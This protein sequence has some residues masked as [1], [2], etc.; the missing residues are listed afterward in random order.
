MPAQN[1]TCLL[2]VRLLGRVAVVLETGQSVR[3]GPKATAL[4]ALLLVDR[5]DA[6]SRDDLIALLWDDRDI[7][8]ARACLRQA[9]ASLRRRL[10]GC[11]RALRTDQQSVAL[12][13]SMVT[14]DVGRARAAAAGDDIASLS[15]ARAYLRERL[16]AGLAVDE[17]GFDEWLAHERHALQQLRSNTLLRLVAAFRSRR[18]LHE[19]LSCATER[20][21]IDPL[22]E[23]AHRLVIALYGELED[24]AAARRQYERCTKLLVDE[25]GVEPDSRTET[26]LKSAT[27][28]RFRGT[29]SAQVTRVRQP[30]LKLAEPEVL[31]GGLT[32][33]LAARGFIP[34]V[35][36]WLHDVPGLRLLKETRTSERQKPS[37]APDFTLESAFMTQG[38]TLRLHLGLTNREGFSL[39]MKSYHLADDM[40]ETSWSVMAVECA[41]MIRRHAIDGMVVTRWCDS[42]V[43]DD[44][45]HAVLTGWAQLRRF[46]RSGLLAA[47]RHFEHALSLDQDCLEAQSLLAEAHV[48]ETSRGYLHGDEAER[49]LDA[50]KRLLDRVRVDAAHVADFHIADAHLAICQRRYDDALAAAQ[51][52]VTLAPSE[53]DTSYALAVVL[54]NLGDAAAALHTSQRMASLSPCSG[55]NHWNWL[56]RSYVMSDE[57]LS[58]LQIGL[59]AV[60][61]WHWHQPMYVPLIWASVEAGEIDLARLTA[62]R[63]LAVDPTFSV[64]REC[65][66]ELYADHGLLRRFRDSLRAA[67]LPG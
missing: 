45:R 58:G 32:A 31:G 56:V 43:H 40:S 44:V 20:V 23:A 27:I 57:P 8:Q 53:A 7:T 55:P 18:D 38:E 1:H 19:A 60:D 26:A 15:T 21:D 3:L 4:L 24:T 13:R 67:E 10:G 9:L 34:H 14:T 29:T 39:W 59:D 49:R 46:T 17:P 48:C 51:Q 66:E 33:R 42:I 65:R 28:S 2:D 35:A 22:D 62:R 61:A 36:S 25:L 5:R 30:V 52:A 6:W 41:A 50:A 11:A 47:R 37:Q 16:L 54:V 63:M 12:D 64:E